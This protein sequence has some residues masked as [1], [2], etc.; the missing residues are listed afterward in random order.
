MAQLV[1][2]TVY[3]SL[4]SLFDKVGSLILIPILTAALTVDD[5]G[6]LMTAISIVGLLSLVMY[7]GLHSA[8]FRWYASWSE[9]WEK[10]LYEKYILVI[11]GTIAIVIALITLLLNW[12]FP[13]TKL[14]SVNFW[15]FFS[16]FMSAVVLIPYTL[17]T[18]VW[19]I[20]GN[21]DYVMLFALVKTVSSVLFVWMLISIYPSPFTKP[22]VEIIIVGTL[23]SILVYMILVQGPGLLSAPQKE[24]R[25]IIKS[26]FA[27]GWLSQISQ[28]AYWVI[29][30]SDRFM[31]SHMIGA[32]VVAVYS[33]AMIGVAP[34]FI[35]TSFNS[36]F[37]ANYMRMHRDSVPIEQLNE[38]VTRYLLIG[39]IF[40]GVYKIMLYFYGKHIVQILSTSEYMMASEIMFFTADI[41]LFYFSYLLFSRYF[42]ALLKMKTIIYAMVFASIVNIILN[43]TLIPIYEI[44]GS[45][46]SS[47]ASYFLL[48]GTV[49]LALYNQVGGRPLA[50]MLVCFTTFVLLNFVLDIYLI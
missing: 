21:S 16:V 43:I 30:S 11:T 46:Y 23:A 42:H 3:L 2:S 26:S 6:Q 28:I 27:Y 8:L 37:S 34:V 5:F 35:V 41:L 50:P 14:L 7:N 29:S 31:L 18:N 10:S 9:A 33:I 32:N 1:K 45:I 39:A 40:I 12:L 49:L 15:L 20:N 17:K 47:V 22:F 44:R 38:Y 13:I 19:V 48:S 25:T 24:I 36:V 4:A